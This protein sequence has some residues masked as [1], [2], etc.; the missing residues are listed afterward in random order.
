MCKAMSFAFSI[1]LT[2]LIVAPASAQPRC[3]KYDVWANG[4]PAALKPVAKRGAR[5]AWSERVRSEIG[6]DYATWGRAR[7]QRTS[8]LREQRM[9]SC[10]VSASPCKA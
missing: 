8:C 7:H 10:T 9:Y 4:E 1:A 6:A 2:L 3:Q 5:A